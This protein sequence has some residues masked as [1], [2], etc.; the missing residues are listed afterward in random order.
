M[1]RLFFAFEIQAPWPEK[2]PSGRV[3]DIGQRHCTVV[4]L[5]N[6]EE[7]ILLDSLS[8]IPLPPFTLAP[9]GIFDHYMFL[10]VRNPRVAAWHVNWGPFRETM[11]DYWEII[12]QFLQGKGINVEK[13]HNFLPHVTLAR[14]PFVQ[15]DWEDIFAMT[16][17]LATS[18]ALY[19]SL[20]CSRYLKIWEHP[21]VMPWEEIE[22]TAD[23]AFTISGRTLQELQLYAQLALAFKY[24]PLA[25]YIQVLSSPE[26]IDDIIIALNEMIGKADAEIG[27]PLKAV[28][29]HG[30]AHRVADL[31]QWE[32]IVDV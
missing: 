25:S 9:G 7:T 23:I 19:E 24:P 11:N 28:S 26:T 18:F 12:H 10:P 5:G 22:H 1:K 31:L 6:L 2:L 16:P 29:F 27:C 21:Y 15:K 3:L 17:L 4:F 13:K 20:G 32:M 14:K 30:E 8:E